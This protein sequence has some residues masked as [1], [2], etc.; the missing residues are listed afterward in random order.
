MNDITNKKVLFVQADNRVT[1]DYGEI[2]PH[3]K[4]PLYYTMPVNKKVC[5]HLKYDY[6]FIQVDEEL[7]NSCM[8][9]KPKTTEWHM[10][11]VKIFIVDKIL[12]E[13]DIDI[14][15]FLDCDAWVQNCNYLNQL[16]CTL[17]NDENKIGCF[18]RDPY[19]IKNTF[20]NSGVFILKVNDSTRKMYDTIKY[21]YVHS[22]IPENW[23]NMPGYIWG[24]QQYIS[25]YVYDNKEDYF[26]FEPTILN[27]PVGKIIRHNWWKDTRLNE[28]TDL[29]INEN[30][31]NQMKYI[32]L[33][34]YLDNKPWPNKHDEGEWVLNK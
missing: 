34:K 26:I 5:E 22:P 14:L 15:V 30:F 31:E 9:L 25:S 10:G 29:L 11:F 33:D 17:N 16:I 23:R 12:K 1:L 28:D 13:T 20:V 21:N 2:L 3:R 27:S 18:S 4:T 24:D 6:R 19:M 8:M 7:I 32:D